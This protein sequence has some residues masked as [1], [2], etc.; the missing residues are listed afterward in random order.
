MK[1]HL[2]DGT[3]ELFR[4]YFGVPSATAPDGREVG[5]VRG[6]VQTM[7]SLLRQEDVT[8]VGVAF[9][10]VIKSFRN[11]LFDGYKTG[12]G[13][14]EE[15]LGQ[16][17][18]AEEA[19]EALGVVVW[20]MV[21]FEADDAIASAAIRFAE[22]TRVDEVVVCSPDKDLAQIVRGRRVVCLDRRRNALLDHQGVLVKFGVEPASIPDYLGLVGDSADGIPGIPRWGAKTSAAVLRRY[23]HIEQ[24]PADSALWDVRVRGAKG[25]AESLAG[26]L[27]DALFY[28]ELA[29]LRLDVPLT[30]SLDDLEWRGVPQRAFSE[31]RERLGLQPLPDQP[32]S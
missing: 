11:E 17:P 30:E 23:G 21:E 32:G 28:R 20:P 26:R 15:L 16:F 3:Y 22:E 8:H 14:P 13:V 12:E 18:L 4:A 31:L 6:L 19:M 2:V 25:A 9:D 27:E 29:T 7:L 10:T 1:V 5:A 24:V